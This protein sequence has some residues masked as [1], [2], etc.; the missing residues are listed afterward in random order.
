MYWV[1]FLNFFINLLFCK[2]FEYPVV[3]IVISNFN[4]VEYL[5]DTICSVINQ[6]YKNWECIIIDDGSVDNTA[7]IVN[8]F[9]K[10][11][12]RIKYI[13]QANA[14]RSNFVSSVNGIRKS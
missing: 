4:K 5:S 6:T 8:A 12:H 9:S 1:F 11:D 3:S 10:I 7:E 2:M 13:F 14:E